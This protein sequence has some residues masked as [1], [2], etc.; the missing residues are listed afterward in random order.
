[1]LG[2]QQ[3]NPAGKLPQDV[4]IGLV[5]TLTTP[6]ILDYVILHL[7]KSLHMCFATNMEMLKPGV[8]TLENLTRGKE[9]LPQVH[10]KLLFT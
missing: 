2:D 10:V 6:C 8:E 7:V 5:S 9:L 1:M 3:L 4:D